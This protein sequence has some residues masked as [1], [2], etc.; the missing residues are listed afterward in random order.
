MSLADSRSWPP[1]WNDR[2]DVNGLRLL[3]FWRERGWPIIHVR[4]DSTDPQSS[5]RS[6][7]V[8]NGFRDGFEPE[9]DEAVVS[10][11]VNAAFIGT[12]LD[13][14][15]RQLDATELVFFGMTT[16]QCVSTT[17]RLGS[18]LGWQCTL[19]EDACD[20]FELPSIGGGNVPARDVHRAHVATLAFEFCSVLTTAD[21]VREW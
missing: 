19:V 1:R 12:D 3:E 6:G 20:C 16:D 5:L 11:S 14:L 9:R 4:H 2:A 18:N 15:L 10:K 13:V 17:V 7:H 21:L 8:G